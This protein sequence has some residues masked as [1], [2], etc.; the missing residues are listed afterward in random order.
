MRTRWICRVAGVAIVM[1]VN[2]C[3][4]EDP[5]IAAKRAQLCAGPRITSIEQR[6]QLMEEGY[7]ILPGWDCI[8]RESWE[9]M[10]R[11]KAQYQARR[12]NADSQ[13]GGA[14]AVVTMPALRKSRDGFTTRVSGPSNGMPLPTPPADLFIR[15][16]YKNPQGRMLAAYVTPDPR[17][18]EKHA[19]IV[20]LTG[21]DSSTLDDFWTEGSA[22]N[23]QSASAFRKAG[24]V[25]M[26]PTLRGGNTD[27]GSKEFFFG[28]VDDVLAAADRLAQLPY[29]DAQH[30]YLGG[31][32]T[33]GTLA[34]LT[35]EASTRFKAVFAF[36]AVSRIERYPTSLVP[37]LGA[38]ELAEARLRS[39]IEWLDGLTTPTWLIEGA[40]APGNREELDELCN[41]TRNPAV[42][43]IA[44]P[45]FNHFSVLTP[46]TRVIGGVLWR[47]LRRL[48][49]SFMQAV[50]E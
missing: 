11:E 9:F 18:G 34:L 40:E 47:T 24:L 3:S 45:G 4:R 16:D 25:M 17:D 46:V 5:A 6:Q 13:R 1:L 27:T 14:P 7:V 30:V 22:S 36:G 31:H 35:A 39:P 43:C 41:H 20:W 29:V 44:V 2:G 21:G 37:D 33:G 48:W 32:S 49:P 42:H 19:A 38:M 8:S 10:Q 12:K 23:D 50:R 28:E 26:F 15:S